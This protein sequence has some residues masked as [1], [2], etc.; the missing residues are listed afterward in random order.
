MISPRTLSADSIFSM[1]PPRILNVLKHLENADYV[2]A[3]NAATSEV[4]A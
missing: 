4:L 1:N 2:V 3:R